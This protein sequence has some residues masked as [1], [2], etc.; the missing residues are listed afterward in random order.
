[1]RK[2]TL[3]FLLRGEGDDLEVLLAM[4]KRGFGRGK[5]NGCGGKVEKAETIERAMIREAEEEIGVK[6]K[7]F[8]QVAILTFTFP[9]VP[10]EKSWDQEIHVFTGRE[11]E[12]EPRETEEMKPQWFAAK[13]LPFAQMWI[14]DPHWLP[15]I[16]SGQKIRASFAFS[17]AGTGIKEKKIEKVERF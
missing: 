4:K 9:D 12:G 15:Q 13:R 8:A 1:M 11:A 6:P 5:W 3:Y 2:G 14:D 17:G 10:K 16:L 7:I